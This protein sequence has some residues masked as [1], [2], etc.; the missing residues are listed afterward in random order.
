MIYFTI[1]IGVN[2]KKLLLFFFAVSFASSSFAGRNIVLWQLANYLN[3]NIQ[4]T[5][6]EDLF[7]SQAQCCRVECSPESYSEYSHDCCSGCICVCSCCPKESLFFR[8]LDLCCLQSLRDHAAACQRPIPPKKCPQCLTQTLSW[9]TS[10]FCCGVCSGLRA[11]YR[12]CSARLS[13]K[14]II[15]VILTELKK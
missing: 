1:N 12:E 5:D 10:I 11:C 14:A 6:T 13:N 2:R 8:L 9:I 3:P 4:L 15:E 7:E